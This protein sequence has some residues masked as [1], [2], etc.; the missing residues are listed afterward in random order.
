M[1]IFFFYA[2]NKNKATN[3]KPAELSERTFSQENLC[4]FF[5]ETFH[6]FLFAM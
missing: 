1:G 5:A 6:I 2:I 3:N 4:V